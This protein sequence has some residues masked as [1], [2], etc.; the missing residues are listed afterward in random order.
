M[1]MLIIAAATLGLT[2]SA[3]FAECAY[4]QKSAQAD[5]NAS[6]TVKPQTESVVQ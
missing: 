5:T 1:K 6:N 3:A 2:A 4:H